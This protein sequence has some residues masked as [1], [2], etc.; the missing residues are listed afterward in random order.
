VP[1]QLQPGHLLTREERLSLRV[2]VDDLQRQADRTDDPMEHA[3]LCQLVENVE[4]ERLN[5]KAC[6]PRRRK[7][8]TAGKGGGRL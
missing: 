1:V 3:R 4:M 5:D 6:R 8:K 7:Q 2:A